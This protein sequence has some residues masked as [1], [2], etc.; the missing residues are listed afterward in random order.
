MMSAWLAW[1]L[2]VVFLTIVGLACLA[3]IIL[4]LYDLWRFLRKW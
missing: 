3:V 4:W 2:R 1:L